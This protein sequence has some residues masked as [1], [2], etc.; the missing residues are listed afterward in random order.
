M[1]SQVLVGK[2]SEQW[3]QGSWQVSHLCSVDR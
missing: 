3:T 1:N 2:I